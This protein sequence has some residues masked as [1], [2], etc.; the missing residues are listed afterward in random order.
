TGTGANSQPTHWVKVGVHD[1]FE[2]STVDAKDG[3]IVRFRFLPRNHSVTSCDLETPCVPNGHFDSGHQFTFI[4]NSTTSVDYPIGNNTN[5]VYF[6]S[7][8][9]GVC[10]KGMVFAI[11]TQADT[12]ASFSAKAKAFSESTYGNGT[13]GWNLSTIA[14]STVLTTNFTSVVNMTKRKEIAIPA[15]IWGRGGGAVLRKRWF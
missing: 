12:F 13:A 15:R 2:P 11:N 5:P 14:N 6:Y 1:T 3:D 10:Q 7:K 4:Q 8:Q 9:E